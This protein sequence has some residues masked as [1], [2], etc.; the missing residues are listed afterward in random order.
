MTTQDRREK[1][2]EAEGEDGLLVYT[3]LRMN[4]LI[5]KN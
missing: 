4:L 5:C 1:V 2:F 3:N